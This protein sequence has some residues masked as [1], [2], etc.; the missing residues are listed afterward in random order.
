MIGR[1]VRDAQTGMVEFI[2]NDNRASQSSHTPHDPAS[3]FHYVLLSYRYI[4]SLSPLLT[5]NTHDTA[6]Y[7][8]MYM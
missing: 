5:A 4:P 7:L 8:H 6:T 3:T 2:N 1:S